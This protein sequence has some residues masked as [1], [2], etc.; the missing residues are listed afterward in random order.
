MIALS[1]Q[2]SVKTCHFPYQKS[3]D[4]RPAAVPR[5]TSRCC[6]DLSALL[7]LAI[8]SFRRSHFPQICQSSQHFCDNQDPRDT[9]WVS[10][11]HVI[12]GHSERRIP[13]SVLPEESQVGPPCQ[14]YPNRLLKSRQS[15]LSQIEGLLEVGAK[16]SFR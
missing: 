14:S 7:G 4:P 5:R 15:L 13:V 2:C 6:G 1:Y 9:Q 10:Q 3:I 8:I 16:S 11:V 12:S